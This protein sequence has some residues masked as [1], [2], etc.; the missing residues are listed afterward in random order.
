[1][2]NFK[3]LIAAH[4]EAGEVE[5]AR[6]SVSN[7]SQRVVLTD[8]RLLLF[9]KVGRKQGG[10][11]VVRICALDDIEAVTPVPAN[12]RGQGKKGLSVAVDL[13]DE[14]PLTAP[15]RLTAIGPAET[16]LYNLVARL[17]RLRPNTNTAPL[18]RPRSSWRWLFAGA[19]IACVVIGL[20]I[21]HGAQIVW[22]E[23]HEATTL[24]MVD[25]HNCYDSQ[26]DSGDEELCNVAVHYEVGTRTYHTTMGAINARDIFRSTIVVAYPASNPILI[27]PARENTDRLAALFGA[28]A[29]AFLAMSFA[30]FRPLWRYRTDREQPSEGRQVVSG[31]RGRHT[32]ESGKS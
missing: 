31:G 11:D 15:L 26:S 28:A 4:L 7:G 20:L 17:K 8:R 1:M 22:D 10:H 9:R 14:T 32:A 16:S 18:P 27:V 23:A 12:E 2:A 5:I 30:C 25:S 3:R 13:R 24:A 19:G 29:I 21:G 6:S